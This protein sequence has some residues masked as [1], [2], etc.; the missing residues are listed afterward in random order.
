M[1]KIIVT[2]SFS[3]FIAM[4]VQANSAFY[5]GGSRDWSQRI[6]KFKAPY[7]LK[8][9]KDYEREQKAKEKYSPTNEASKSTEIKEKTIETPINNY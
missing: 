5:Q 4:S 6:N 8:E 9:I 1:K 2:F 3:L 7:K